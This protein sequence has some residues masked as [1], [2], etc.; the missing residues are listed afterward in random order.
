MHIHTTIKRIHKTLVVT[1]TNRRLYEQYAHRFH[2]S[3][4][5]DSLKLVVYSEDAGLDIRTTHLHLQRD[6]V[7]RNQH[8]TVTSYKQD[9]V[10]F[11]YKVYAIA[12][13]LGDYAYDD[14]DRLLWIDSDTVFLKQFDEEWITEHL[15]KQKAIMGYAGRPRTHS[16]CGLLLFN[17][18][19]PKTRAYIGTVRNYYDTDNLYLLPE[20]HDSYIW[21]SVRTHYEQQGHPFNN[22]AQHM[23]NRVEGNHILAHLYGEWMDHCKG[24]R[25]LQGYS[26]EIKTVNKH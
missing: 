12:Q 25:K 8:R 16:E 4:P 26:R 15:H 17:L 18:E 1:S 14:Y 5:H 6:F 10:R 11:C 21:D 7:Q 24:K 13:A 23:E 2:G 19:H 9:A 22:W 20:Q 3:F